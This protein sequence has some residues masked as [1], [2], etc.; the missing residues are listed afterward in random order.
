MTTIQ[1][2][3][4]YTGNVLYEYEATDEQ[5]SSRLK[6]RAALESAVKSDAD[7]RDADLR[8]AYLRGAYLSGADLRGAYL[9]G[10]NLSG[11]Y[12]RGAY[13]RGAN[14]SG[15]DLI[16]ANLRGANL[17]GA[18]LRGADLSGAYLGGA[19]L[20]GADLSDA[21][22]RGAN[23]SGADLSG[24]NLRGKKL[25]GDRPVVMVGPIGS[26]SDYL[27]AYLTDGGTYLKT[28]CF[29]GTAADFAAKLTAEHGENKHAQEYRAALAL[30]E[31]HA[32]LWSPAQDKQPDAEQQ[33]VEQ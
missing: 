3:H 25:V 33:G 31:C 4:R 18:Y 14:L 22:L 1:I 26:R 21:Y 9:R 16:D 7:L 15:A 23:L 17:S 2:K 10:A 11:A 27:T 8:G 32:N 24:A 20:S 13:L 5:Q 19:D 6:M 28:G 30:I 29:F 12:L